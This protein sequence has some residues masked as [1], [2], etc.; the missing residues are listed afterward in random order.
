MLHLLLIGPLHQ[1]HIVV[2]YGTCARPRK[3]LTYAP[4]LIVV[5]RLASYPIPTS[6]R[7]SSTP[8]RQYI[9]LG[10]ASF[11]SLCSLLIAAS[12]A[13]VLTAVR[14]QTKSSCVPVMCMLVT[15]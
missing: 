10:I 7:A 9:A 15:G 2:R 4:G 11:S 3:T 13:R 5:T 8:A 14:D 12:T 1:V 6:M